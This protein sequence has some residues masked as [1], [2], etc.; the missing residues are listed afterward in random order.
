M[1]ISLFSLVSAKGFFLPLSGGADSAATCAMVGIMCKIVL[2]EIHEKKNE[3]VTLDAMRIADFKDRRELPRDHKALCRRIFYTCYMGTK[4]SSSETKNRAQKL[5]DEVGSKH[6]YIEIDAIVDSFQK[7]F[8]QSFDK[9]PK[10]KVFFFVLFFFIRLIEHYFICVFFYLFI[11]L[12]S[13]TWRYANRKSCIAEYS[14]TFSHGAILF[15]CSIAA[16]D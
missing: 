15:T 10:F 3:Q 2:N 13:G 16:M 1:S 6:T 8:S 5:A 12:F 11:Y 14:S 4:N 9:T 7:V